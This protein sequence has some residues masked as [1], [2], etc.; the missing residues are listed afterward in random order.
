MIRKAHRWSC[1]GL[2]IDVR[3]GM[4]PNCVWPAR[5]DKL[6]MSLFGWHL[7]ADFTNEWSCDVDAAKLPGGLHI[8]FDQVAPGAAMRGGERREQGRAR[9]ALFYGV[10]SAE[11]RT[12][13]KHMRRFKGQM[14]GA[15][16]Y[17]SQQLRSRGRR[18]LLLHPPETNVKCGPHPT[19]KPVLRHL[20]QAALL[21]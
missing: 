10:D 16:R 9:N 14:C 12:L 18:L 19:H 7:S 11:K 17:F 21:G 2:S 20:L 15:C 13:L 3:M 5:S 1:H 4:P 6:A 8:L